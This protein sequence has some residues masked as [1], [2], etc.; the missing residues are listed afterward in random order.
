MSSDHRLDSAWFGMGA[1]IKEKAFTE[2]L[3]LAA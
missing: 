2:A 3:K 1:A